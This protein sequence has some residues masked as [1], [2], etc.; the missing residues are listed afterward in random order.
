MAASAVNGDFRRKAA[1]RAAGPAIGIARGKKLTERKNASKLIA[2]GGLYK[3]CRMKETQVMASELLRKAASLRRLLGVSA[4][5]AG[6]SIAGS[7]SAD[8]AQCPDTGSPMPPRCYKEVRILNNTSGKIYVV[9]Q[10]SIIK[11]A[12]IGT[13]P[14]GGDVWLQRALG[15][16][17]QCLPVKH[18]YHIYINPTT[19][20]DKGQVA[21]IKLPW[22][23]KRRP[24]NPPSDTYVDWWRSGRLYIFDDPKALADIYDKE[25]GT[26]QVAFAANSP[27][28]ECRKGMPS[29][30]CSTVQIWQ[31]KPIAELGTQ[32][33]AQLNEY[34]F[35]SVLGPDPKPALNFKFVNFN[36][37]YN[38]SN[39]DQAYLPVAMEPIRPQAD[40]GYMGTVISVAAFRKSLVAFAGAGAPGTNPTNWPVYNNPTV[41]GQLLYPKAGIRVP[42]AETV[43]NFYMK[44]YFF[45]GDLAPDS[46]PQLLPY[47]ANNP[48]P[49]K[50]V[51]ELM[52]RWKDCTG[53]DTSECPT[54][55][56][57]KWTT[58]YTSLN[59]NFVTN[60]GSWRAAI[61]AG[62]C[63]APDPDYLAPAP[64]SN[65]PVPANKYAL[66]RYIYGWVPFNIGCNAAATKQQ[67]LP[68]VA[69]GNK[70]PV[71]YEQ[72]QYNYDIFPK[73]PANKSFNPYTPMVHNAV[74]AGGLNSNA[75]AFSIDDKT[76][77]QSNSGSGLIFAVG[78]AVGLPN[79]TKVLP[80][81]PSPFA[82]WDFGIFIGPA[83]N[84]ARWTKY[85]ICSA[86]A[87]MDFPVQDAGFAIGVDP[88]ISNI[89]C[90]V[91]L[92]DSNGVIYRLKI[93]QALVPPKPIWPFWRNAQGYDTNVLDCSTTSSKPWCGFVNE[94]TIPIG[95]PDGPIY[96]LNTRGP[97]E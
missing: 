76:A 11:Q 79:K 64:N 25:R 95:Q 97:I 67:E 75:Y 58:F 81:V 80:T 28:P 8:T 66:L 4:M 52:A 47:N 72:V 50:L 83:N 26:P 9:L 21:S 24:V 90:Q 2:T 62:N 54:S 10:G 55:G 18:N 41:D 84:S 51:T 36:Q 86:V 43:L 82:Q 68:T 44:P 7:A 40:I 93:K 20:I 89:P 22:W 27:V 91:T 45:G 53:S 56:K 42:S 34:T 38:V 87:N 15:I 14:Q 74:A 19:G 85:G 1:H 60:Y 70:L 33:P 88:A 3:Q 29:N 77:F 61:T 5:V 78:G 96:T 59:Q 16:V 69:Q 46:I 37:N 35:A 49:P 94:K 6:I 71:S 17:N 92:E 57:V 48:V 31:V 63:T 65:P 32:T 73:V 30:V 23:S 13:C 12:A 39:V